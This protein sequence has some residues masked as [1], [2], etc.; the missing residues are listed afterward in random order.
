MLLSFKKY[1]IKY[2]FFILLFLIFLIPRLVGLGYDVYGIDAGRWDFRSDEFIK[3]FLRGDFLKTNQKYHPGVTLMWLSGLSKKLF[4]TLFKLK[5]GYSPVLYP[6]TVY[7]EWFFIKNFIAKFPVVTVISFLISY[8]LYL[9]H[10]M[11]INKKYLLFF[12]VFLS[13]EPFFLGISRFYHLS[14][15]EASFSFVGYITILYY[16]FSKRTRYLYLSGVFL[17]FGLLT[18]TSVAIVLPFLGLTMFYLELKE[19]LNSKKL[20]NSLFR[21]FYLSIFRF[22]IVLFVSFL[23]FFLFFPAMWVRPFWVVQDIINSGVKDTAFGD[24]RGFSFTKS[25]YLYYYEMLFIRSTGLII[26]SFVAS[27]FLVFKEKSKPLKE[28]L[29]LLLLYVIYYNFVM[30]FPSK[31]KD[32]YITNVLPFFVGFSSYALY[33]L[34]V[35]LSKKKTAL[36]FYRFFL[37][38]YLGM[39]FYV[40]YPNFSAYHTDLLGGY[41]GYSKL[42]KIRNRG[43]F[44]LQVSQ[45]LNKRDGSKAYEKAVVS[46]RGESD[47]SFKGYLGTVFTSE[48]FIKKGSAS[49]YVA[50]YSDLDDVPLDR[51]TLIKSFGPRFPFKFDYLLVFSCSPKEKESTSYHLLK[52]KI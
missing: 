25:P 7:P 19:N 14:G 35:Y 49:Y 36:Y 48:S 4:Y 27:L 47:R 52:P 10:K 32:R 51:C 45:Y 11:N 6:G 3:Y 44:Y 28:L 29:F 23:T 41:A 50:D 24:K 21:A 17:G 26:I 22:L 20:L 12:A 9:L 42:A 34:Y 2:R 43:E 16:Y 31:L 33:K 13:L 38:F 5:T 18:K 40:Y 39:T 30:S 37:V 46:P 1:L 8:S 15:M